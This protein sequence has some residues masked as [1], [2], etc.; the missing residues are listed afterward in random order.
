[1]TFP[2]TEVQLQSENFGCLRCL[3]LVMCTHPFAKKALT[4][5]LARSEGYE[6]YFGCNLMHRKVLASSHQHLLAEAPLERSRCEF[7][8]KAPFWPWLGLKELVAGRKRWHRVSD[9][10]DGFSIKHF[11][12]P[13]N[14]TVRIVIYRKRVRIERRRTSSSTCFP[15]TTATSSTQPSPRTNRSPSN[16]FGTSLLGEAPKRKPS[17]NCEASS[18]SMWC[19][20]KAMPPI[21]PGNS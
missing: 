18:L 7:A 5:H 14:I 21:A 8:I 1:M 19:R 3:L 17:P 13:W 6:R 4:L 20:P 10:I 15:Q 12:K 16:A 2:R 11:I 9:G